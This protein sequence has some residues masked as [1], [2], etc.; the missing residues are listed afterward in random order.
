MIGSLSKALAITP[1]AIV[2]VG[3]ILVAGCSSPEEKA[4][5]YYE[6]GQQFLSQK[7]YVKAGIEFRNALQL[8]KDLIGAWRGLAQIEERDKNWEPLAAV[9][10]TIVDLD[11]KD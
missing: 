1:R 2:L 7:D 11:P 3:F 8:K 5:N 6:R 10:R 9:L 4:Q